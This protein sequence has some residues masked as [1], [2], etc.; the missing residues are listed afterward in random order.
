MNFTIATARSAAT[1][2]TIL[3]DISFPMPV[4]LMNGVLIYDIPSKHYI[5]IEYLPAQSLPFIHKV[6]KDC[7]LTGFMYEIKDHV[8]STYYE[9][10]ET[11]ALRDFYEERVNKYQKPFRQ[12]SDFSAADTG[13][14]IYFALLD[15]KERLD[16]ACQILKTNSDIAVAYYKDIYSGD[17]LWYLEISSTNATKYNA[18]QY[19][20]NKYHYDTIIGFGDNLNDLP[21]FRA[22]DVTCAVNNAKEELKETAT[23]IIESNVKNGVVNWIRR[24]II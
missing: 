5:N 11:K 2:E 16:T 20:R 24:N 13:H 10:L 9:R 7:Q 15:S 19:L 3:R 17:G 14:I 18:V 6:L 23:Y 21:L 4:I 22:C 12:V 1:I 8:Q